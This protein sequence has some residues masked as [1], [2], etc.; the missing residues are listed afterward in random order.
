MAKI[1]KSLQDFKNQAAELGLTPYASLYGDRR[2]LATWKKLLAGSE[3][4]VPLPKRAIEVPDRAQIKWKLPIGILTGF[5]I[6]L[7]LSSSLLFVTGI[8]VSPVR[9]KIEIGAK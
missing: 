2:Q 4:L 5:A 3:E 7:L 8:K 1:K 6:G 9:I